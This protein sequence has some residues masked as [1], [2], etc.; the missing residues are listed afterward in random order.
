MQV[1]DYVQAL[2]DDGL[3]CADKI[4]SGNW[5][6]SFP[7]DACLAKRAELAKAE[8]ERERLGAVRAQL[9]AEVEAVERERREGD[10]EGGLVGAAGERDGLIAMRA[11]LDAELQGLRAELAAYR[12]Q[13]PA[14]VE[15]QRDLAAR[16]KVEAEAFTEKILCMEAWFKKQAGGDKGLL[17]SMKQ[18]W[19][20]DEFDEEELGLREL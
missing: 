2:A 16:R 20:G 7:R 9:T 15:R 8:A 17:L 13:D 18:M 11:A 1:K 4:G 19:Y 3:L 5:Y 14:E 10:G 12:E 6:W